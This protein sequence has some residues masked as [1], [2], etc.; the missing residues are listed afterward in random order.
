MNEQQKNEIIELIEHE[1]DMTI[2][3]I[4]PDNLPH[5][6]TV[7]Y[8]NDGLVLYFGTSSNSQKSINIESNGNIALTINS[9]YR[10][11]KDIEGISISGF[12]SRVTNPEEYINV[13]KLLFEKFPQVNEFANTETEE[14]A[15]FRIEPKFISHLNYRKG[16]GHTEHH[17]V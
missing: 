17:I 9:P 3:T 13:G 5:A 8:V 10:F 6:T 4:R 15:L 2:A 7:S 14:T 12:V 1:A 11:W 16:F